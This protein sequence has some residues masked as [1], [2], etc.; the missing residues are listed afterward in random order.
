MNR[1]CVA[2]A[3][4]CLAV[5]ALAP[6]GLT[7]QP[8]G[9]PA[10]QPVPA[11]RPKAGIAVASPPEIAAQG[12][13]P[14]RLLQMGHTG[15]VTAIAFSPDG[16]RLATGSYD[17]AVR[18]WDVP[19]GQE[20]L[21]LTG[22]Q[23]MITAIAFSPDGHHLASGSADGSF[24]VSDA[25]TGATLYSRDFRQWID[26]VAFSPD[27]QYLAV[28]IQQSEEEEQSSA[29]IQIF[30]AGNG[31]E[32]R[33]VPLTWSSA[34]QLAVTADNRLI[35]SGF[36]G[37][38]DPVNIWDIAGGQLLNSFPIEAQAISADGRWAVTQEFQHGG[39]V[40]LWDLKTGRQVWAAPAPYSHIRFAFSRDGQQLLLADQNHS[41]MKLWDTATGKEIKTFPGGQSVVRSVVFSADGSSIAAGAAD[42]SITV[43]DTA[44]ARRLHLLPAQLAVMAVAFTSPGG[45]LAGDPQGLVLWDVSSAKALK[46]ISDRP[47]TNITS[48]P[49]GSWLAANPDYQLEVWNAR[50]WQPATL[51]PAANARTFYAAFGGT[52]PPAVEISDPAV[53]WSRI[54]DD[55]QK[56][57][58]WRSLYPLAI[59]P[60][61][62]LLATSFMRGG[63]VTIW[64]ART[65]A[66]LRTISTSNLGVN[67]L[68]F[69]P[70]GRWLLTGGQMT[71][72][73]PGVSLLEVKYG[74]ELWD[75]N[76]WSE[77]SF[78]MTVTGGAA[79][80]FSPNGQLLAL[81]AT[82]TTIQLFDLSQ[83]K[84]VEALA[85][86]DTWRSGFFVFSPDGK[87]LAQPGRQGI[88]LWSVAGNP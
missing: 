33:T 24:V 22:H 13:L 57:I 39:K 40:A 73:R 25:E 32:L 18:L 35:S 26:A 68:T 55:S 27:G 75:V 50:T 38:E 72:I 20:E 3:V 34:P 66:K 54:S 16:R 7:Q 70:D 77:R 63:D 62:K 4:L 30:R 86:T 23:K 87:W 53:S 71:P 88:S 84:T 12:R 31:E 29:S 64:D 5:L 80:A 41:E 79:A 59:S 42:G 36:E 17:N 74:F 8:G 2:L 76:S 58:V 28:S 52:Q 1:P 56:R 81:G 15:E 45:L 14:D 67:C 48:S 19:A 49:D 47:V 44:T 9:V 21:K 65:G 60:D 11:Q 51:A 83:N 37:E 10:P 43:W 61:G 69:S 46:R 85:S 82:A 6:E 78:P